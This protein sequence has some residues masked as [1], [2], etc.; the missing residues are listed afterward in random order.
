MENNY[1]VNFNDYSFMDEEGT[2]TGTLVYKRYGKK[3][4][5]LANIDLDDGRKIITAAYSDDN[6]YLGLADIAVDSKIEVTFNKT[7]SGL[8]RLKEINIISE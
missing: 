8:V 5:M 1:K 2:Y 3:K 4:N 6:N 7:K